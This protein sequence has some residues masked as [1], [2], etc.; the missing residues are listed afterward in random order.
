MQKVII[1]VVLPPVP[2]KLL[3]LLKI[4]LIS[5]FLFHSC[6]LCLIPNIFQIGIRDPSL[7]EAVIERIEEFRNEEEEKTAE[8]KK[9]SLQVSQVH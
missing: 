8:G 4:Y 2:S 5:F 3:L 9:E 1:Q 6:N 7:R